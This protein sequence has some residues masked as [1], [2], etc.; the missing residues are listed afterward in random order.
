MQRLSIVYRTNNIYTL[1]F[2]F[3]FFR[4]EF[5]LVQDIRM[6]TSGEPGL[7]WK[8]ALLFVSVG[9]VCVTFGAI[10]VHDIH[11]WYQLSSLFF[12]INEMNGNGFEFQ[13]LRLERKMPTRRMKSPI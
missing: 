1:Y 3:H 4:F 12:F 9:L 11:H 7:F 10:G 13:I 6:H 5:E 8:S 2:G